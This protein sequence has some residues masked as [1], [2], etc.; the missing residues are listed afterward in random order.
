MGASFSHFKHTFFMVD[1]DI[2]HSRH[3]YLEKPVQN[4]YG[5]TAT[6]KM[7]NTF[8]VHTRRRVFVCV[9]NFVLLLKFLSCALCVE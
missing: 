6:V 5:G 8:S 3:I 2:R 1:V 4:I 7:L 9:D